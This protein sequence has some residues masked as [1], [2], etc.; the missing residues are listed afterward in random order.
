MGERK[1]DDKETFSIYGSS[2]FPV[3]RVSQLKERASQSMEILLGINETGISFIDP[4]TFVVNDQFRHE[5]IFT[6]GYRPE[7]PAFLFVA[8]ELMNQ[9]KTTL[10]TMEGQAINDLVDIYIQVKV[11]LAQA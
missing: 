4:M 10:S 7:P 3:L 6:Y 5:K 11:N 9:K 8:G 1:K 2:F